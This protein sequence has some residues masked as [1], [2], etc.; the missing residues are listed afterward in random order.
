MTQIPEIAEWFSPMPLELYDYTH[1]LRI[2]HFF[3]SVFPYFALIT[4]ETFYCQ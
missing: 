1:L 3:P 4:L 2:A